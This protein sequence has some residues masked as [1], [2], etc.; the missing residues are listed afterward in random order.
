MLSR[1]ELILAESLQAASFLLLERPVT[2]REPGLF[3]P[4]WDG[5]SNGR[6][7]G[8]GCQSR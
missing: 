8:Q 6:E 3:G 1:V 2:G 7:L 5:G 4:G